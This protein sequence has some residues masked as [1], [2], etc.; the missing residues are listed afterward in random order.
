MRRRSGSRRLA[1][2]ESA[3]ALYA[4]DAVFEVITDGALQRFAGIEDIASGQRAHMAIFRSRGLRVEKRL[5]AATGTT[6]VNEWRGQLARRAQARGAEVWEF[7]AR[8]HVARHRL[9]AFLNV[10]PS[11]SRLARLR[12]AL[13]YPLTAW[14]MVRSMRR[15]G[16]DRGLRG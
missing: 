13:A 11:T 9:Y 15:Y 2:S 7:D 16:A 6:I 4:P 12:I 10:K 3:I 8:G 1:T 14:A 5:T